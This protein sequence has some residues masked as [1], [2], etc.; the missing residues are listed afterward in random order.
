MLSSLAKPLTKQ[1]RTTDRSCEVFD[2]Q[3]KK[4]SG[5]EDNQTFFA[6]F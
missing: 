4:W 1:T 5:S 6:R 2:N 3:R